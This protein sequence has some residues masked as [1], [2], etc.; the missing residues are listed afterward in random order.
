[1][2][3]KGVFFAIGVFGLLCA[4]PIVCE[5]SIQ[6]QLEILQAQLVCGG[7]FQGLEISLGENVPVFF[8]DSLNLNDT[9]LGLVDIAFLSD[10]SSKYAEQNN[11]VETVIQE[12][13]SSPPPSTL[14][15]W[16]I[17]GLCWSG[18]SS[19]REQQSLVQRAIRLKRRQAAR[20]TRRAPWSESTRAAILN[21]I[22]RDCPR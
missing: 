14:L 5:A 6:S 8:S 10:F 4:T 20:T 16:A 18:G 3:Q 2:L 7:Y 17:L 13:P 19:W 12:S 1:M 11:A 21:V 9:R 15:V 22:S